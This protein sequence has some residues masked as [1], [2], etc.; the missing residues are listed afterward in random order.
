MSSVI[1]AIITLIEQLLPAITSAG[2][3]TLIDSI[4]QALVGMM[5]FIIQE[6]QSLAAPVKNIIAALSA[7]PATTADQLA[8][9]QA[10]DTQVDAAFEAAAAQTDADGKTTPTA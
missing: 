10:L 2:N 3:A 1:T 9:L 6:V 4:L 8:Q 5:P 7:N